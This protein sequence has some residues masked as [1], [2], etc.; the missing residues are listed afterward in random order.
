M[1]LKISQFP[2]INELSKNDVFPVLVDGQNYISAIN[3]VYTFLSGDKLIEVY[4]SYS[5]N[6]SV[7][8]SN[9]KL[10]SSV[11]TQYNSN[12]ANYI[13]ITSPEVANWRSSYSSVNSTSSVWNNT[14]SYVS[15]ISSS[16]IFSDSTLVPNSTAI[17]NIIAITQTNFDQLTYID[18]QTF[19]VIAS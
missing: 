18:P 14:N 13:L 9:S 16:F 3:S 4:T 2:V 8:I 5:S 1:N 12:S 7:L 10:L 19:Y 11:Y 17:K 15:G 6:S